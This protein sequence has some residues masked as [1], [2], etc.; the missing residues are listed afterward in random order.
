MLD[1]ELVAGEDGLPSFPQLCRRML[2][3]ERAI[4]VTC[5]ILSTLF[6]S[7]ARA[8][9]CCPT[10]RDGSCSRSSSSPAQPGTPLFAFED[11][12]ALFEV[13]CAHGLAHDLQGRGNPLREAPAW[14]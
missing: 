9:W 5:M 12:E 1:G 14:P 7:M 13:I 8:R 10:Q 4:A 11:G 3:G 2:H 6:T